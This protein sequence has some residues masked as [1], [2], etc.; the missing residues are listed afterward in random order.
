[1]GRLVGEEAG[2]LF[3]RVGVGSLVRQRRSLLVDARTDSYATRA[4]FTVG[5]CSSRS[6]LLVLLLSPSGLLLRFETD[7]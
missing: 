7:S 4:R 5:L 2:S 6:R 3:L 1:M